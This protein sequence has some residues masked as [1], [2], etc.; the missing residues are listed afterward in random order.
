M[1]VRESEWERDLC[2]TTTHS[3]HARI[4]T[5]AHT[6]L[7]MLPRLSKPTQR[8]QGLICQSVDA[9]LIA[10]AWWMVDQDSAGVQRKQLV[11]CWSLLFFLRPPTIPHSSGSLP[12]PTSNRP[13][14][15]SAV[16]VNHRLANSDQLH[17]PEAPPPHGQSVSYHDCYSRYRGKEENSINGKRMGS[18][19]R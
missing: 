3:I 5:H 8:E 9:G 2:H 17:T 15:H 18:R 13:E 12:S 7:G 16:P 1:R 10:L 11:P 19:R 6:P 14:Y 4:P